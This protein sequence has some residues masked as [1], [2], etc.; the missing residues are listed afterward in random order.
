LSVRWE[1]SELRVWN[2]EELT[3]PEVGMTLPTSAISIAPP[4]VEEP[5]PQ[6]DRDAGAP[7][8]NMP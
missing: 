5:A 3:T 8:A 7:A 6:S 2:A 4:T 1:I